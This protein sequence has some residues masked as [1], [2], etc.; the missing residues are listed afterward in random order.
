[1]LYFRQAS[2]N[3][4]VKLCEK[5]DLSHVN[6]IGMQPAQPQITN[7]PLSSFGIAHTPVHKF[8]C[9]LCLQQHLR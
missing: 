8:D 5:I 1:M 2:Y 4:E 7:L 3:E 9:N 6:D